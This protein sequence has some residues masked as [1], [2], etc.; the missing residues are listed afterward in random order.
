[1]LLTKQTKQPEARAERALQHRVPRYVCVCVCI[2][3][4]TTTNAEQAAGQR[5]LRFA[6]KMQYALRNSGTASEQRHACRSYLWQ[7]LLHA[8]FSHWGCAFAVAVCAV[9]LFVWS[10]L[11]L[12]LYSPLFLYLVH[13]L[14]TPSTH[15]RS[16]LQG[17]IF[18]IKYYVKVS[19]NNNNRNCRKL[20][21]K[22]K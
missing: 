7:Q 12:S 3:C 8:C 17:K 22:I 18:P 6:T 13:L 19:K 9:S 4:L 15:L 2:G 14:F 11:Q 1:M 16:A 10:I 21:R 5:D 20:Q